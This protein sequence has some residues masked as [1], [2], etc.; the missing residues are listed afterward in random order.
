VVG[1]V[2]PSDAPYGAYHEHLKRVTDEP[3]ALF[4]PG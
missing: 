4:L 1:R 2:T 3:F